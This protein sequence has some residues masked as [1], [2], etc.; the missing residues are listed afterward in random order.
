[1]EWRFWRWVILRHLAWPTVAW[2]AVAYGVGLAAVERTPLSGLP[3]WWRTPVAGLVLSGAMMGCWL[4][5]AGTLVIFN[6]LL[7]LSP[8]PPT[9]GVAWQLVIYSSV[10]LGILWLIDEGEGFGL[11]EV[12]GQ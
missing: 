9:L 4:L 6:Q 11:P 7:L 3:P 5:T 2:T 1:M 10:L 12:S 8:A